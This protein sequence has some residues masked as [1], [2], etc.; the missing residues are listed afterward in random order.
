MPVYLITV[1]A[2]R[3]WN[4]DNPHGFVRRGEGILPPDMGLAKAYANAATEKPIL[5]GPAEQVTLLRLAQNV[6]A[7]RDWRLHAVACEPSHVHILLSWQDDT[8]VTEVLRKLKNLMSRELNLV[9][10]HRRKH[11]FSRSG[12]RKRVEERSHFDQLMQTYLPKHRGLVWREGE[13]FP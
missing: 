13:E 3:S 7:R 10:E 11:W 5:F 12:S 6:C 2:Y 1:H 9:A 4:P 8:T